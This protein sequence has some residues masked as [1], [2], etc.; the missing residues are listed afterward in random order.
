MA[1]STEGKREIVGL[2]LG[3]SEA[4]TF[5]SAFLKGLVK[6]GLRGV[7]LVISDAHE[8]LKHAIGPPRPPGHVRFA[9]RIDG[10]LAIDGAGCHLAA[11]SCSHDPNAIDHWA[12]RGSHASAVD[13][14]TG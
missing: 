14:A 5:W 9:D 3:P 4:E 11:L 2:G 6:R 8:G 1:V 10:L 7:K 13:C 12:R